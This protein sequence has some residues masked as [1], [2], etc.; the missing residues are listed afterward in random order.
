VAARLGTTT[1]VLALAWVLRHPA[2]ATAIS[3]ATRPDE[4]EE[5]A[6]A[7]TLDIP[8]ALLA[9]ME[10]IMRDAA[11]VGTAIPTWERK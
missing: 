5:N 10:D 6:R 9:E 1:A 8:S 4:I 7:A 2:V 3:G 11:D